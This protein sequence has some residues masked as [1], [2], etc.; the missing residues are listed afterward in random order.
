MLSKITLIVVAN[1]V[2]GVFPYGD[3]VPKSV[4]LVD[5]NGQKIDEFRVRS[6]RDLEN[7]IRMF[8]RSPAPGGSS[9]SYSGS[10]SNAGS[11]P[12]DYVPDFSN[13]AA[14]IP[15]SFEDIQRQTEKF[16]NPSF[17]SRLGGAADHDS[18]YKGP[19]LFSRSGTDKGSG[20]RVSS[21]S[22]GSRGAFSSSSSSIDGQGNIKYNVQSGK[23]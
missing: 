18:G 3:Y 9:Y 7:A 13:F 22:Q 11:N 4:F 8:K 5:E 2:C 15:T 6:K 10:F 14:N 1:L 20:V 19:I 21:A 16:A 17:H 12:H 23:Y